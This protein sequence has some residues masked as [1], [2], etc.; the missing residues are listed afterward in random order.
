MGYI[1]AT[2]ALSTLVLATDVP[3]AERD[4][5]RSPYFELSE[6]HFGI[7]VRYFY[8]HGLAIALLSMGL[9][10]L[11]HRHRKPS[12]IRL[13]KPWRL[14]NRVLACIVMFF[15]PLA[16]KLRSLD[17]VSITLGLTVWVLAVELWGKA[18]KNESFFADKKDRSK[19]HAMAKAIRRDEEN[20][21]GEA[22]NP[23]PGQETANRMKPDHSD[24][25]CF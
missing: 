16:H 12:T 15:L 1:V 3:N 4:Q 17:L 13:A 14:A 10:S 18:C 21:G 7:G 6:A 19:I 8:C 11:S 23:N 5:L 2:S 22:D 9:I 25:C 20:R 24:Q